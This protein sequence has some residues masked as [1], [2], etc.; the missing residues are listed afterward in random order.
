MSM[1][2]FWL[3]LVMLGQ[4]Q[5]LFKNICGELFMTKCFCAMFYKFFHI[6]HILQHGFWIFH[7]Y[8]MIRT[9]F[10]KIGDRISCTGLRNKPILSWVSEN[11]IGIYFS[12]PVK[13]KTFPVGC[14]GI[15]QVWKKMQPITLWKGNWKCDKI[16][17]KRN[18]NII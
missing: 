17:L 16:K 7:V 13:N 9:Y 5:V 4:K 18:V 15:S 1:K 11:Y 8:K 3:I 6:Q 2:N 12:L 14:V 10:W